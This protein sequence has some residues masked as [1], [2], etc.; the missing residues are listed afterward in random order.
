VLANEETSLPY[1]LGHYGRVK[2]RVEASL[3]LTYAADWSEADA[4]AAEHGV[5]VFLVNRQRYEGSEGFRYPPPFREQVARLEERGR[6]RGF[7]LLDPPPE[8][9]LFRRDPY[10]VVRVG[11]PR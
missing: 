7:A 5:G 2:R 8:R 4:I 3:A 6:E 10:V 1:W 11:E 9:V